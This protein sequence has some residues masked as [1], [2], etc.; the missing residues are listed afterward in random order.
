MRKKLGGTNFPQKRSKNFSLPATTCFW[1]LVVP[2]GKLTVLLHELVGKD[3]E[4][5][6]NEKYA[7]RIEELKKVA[8]EKKNNTG[9]AALRLLTILEHVRTPKPRL[10]THHLPTSDYAQGKFKIYRPGRSFIQLGREDR[11]FRHV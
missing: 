5:V 10:N 4:L 8:R 3:G 7:E 9:N 1:S 2:E 6:I 11:Y